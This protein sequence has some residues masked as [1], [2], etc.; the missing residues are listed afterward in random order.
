MTATHDVTGFVTAQQRDEAIIEASK[1]LD[2]VEHILSVLDG[3]HPDLLCGP[4]YRRK[5]DE[6]TTTGNG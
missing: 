2:R 3:L 6:P 1:L 5:G 4:V